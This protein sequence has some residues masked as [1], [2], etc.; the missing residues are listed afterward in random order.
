MIY[1]IFSFM[2][3]K[4]TSSLSEIDLKFYEDQYVHEYSVLEASTP[5]LIKVH[6][7]PD[8]KFEW[9]KHFDFLKTHIEQ[10]APGIVIERASEQNNSD[11][12]MQGIEGETAYT[13]G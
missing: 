6:L 11:I 12:K 4:A 2:G 7:S 13:Q 8:L 3:Q 10:S 1:L 5:K 9:S